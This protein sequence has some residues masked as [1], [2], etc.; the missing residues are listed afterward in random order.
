M[1]P[2]LERAGQ[3]L[4]EAKKLLSEYPHLSESIDVLFEE[5]DAQV[6]YEDEVAAHH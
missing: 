4:L 6:D 2:N 5:I 1:N 3:L